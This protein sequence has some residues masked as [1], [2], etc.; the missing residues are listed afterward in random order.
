[1]AIILDFD[2]KRSEPKWWWCAGIICKRRF[3][4]FERPDITS[5]IETLWLQVFLPHSLGFLLGTFYRPPDFYDKDFVYKT[6]NDLE[7]AACEGREL[8]GDHG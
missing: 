2:L 8:N 4:C 6:E 1:M 5:D 3:E 7:A